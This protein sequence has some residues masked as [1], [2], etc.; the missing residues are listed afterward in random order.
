LFI[1]VEQ[2]KA[3]RA[4][5][6]W[7]QEELANRAHLTQNQISSFEFGRTKPADVLELMYRTFMFHGVT[8]LKN[9]VQLNPES[10]GTIEG[11]GW[12]SRLLDDVYTTLIDQKGAELLI[13]CA[14]DKASPPEINNRYRKMR[15]AGIQMRQLV[16]EGHTNLMGPLKEY[17]YI[18]KERFKNYVS[19][20]YGNKVAVCTEKSLKATVFNDMNL[21]TA[22]RNIFDVLWDKLDKPERSDAHERF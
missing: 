5:L 13:F 6:G 16:E 20:V 7:S 3:A 18:P 17:R 10:V 12:Y 15:N 2:V 8:F 21:A 11:E 19:L 9:G 22:W 1:T 4:L 14:D